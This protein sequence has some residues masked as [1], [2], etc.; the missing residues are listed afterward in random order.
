MNDNIPDSHIHLYFSSCKECGACCFD[1]GLLNKHSGC[2]NEE[3]RLNSRCT[4]FPIL[5]GNPEK[6][7]H[8]NLWGNLES[9]D[10]SKD[11]QW[12]LLEFDKCLLLQDEK[13]LHQ[14]R[15]IIEDINNGQEILGFVVGF[16]KETLTITYQ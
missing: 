3:Y 13:F 4:S 6:M 10:R 12:F 8:N 1:C 9:L 11:K 5:Y 15:W 2:Q 16:D 7:G 14:L